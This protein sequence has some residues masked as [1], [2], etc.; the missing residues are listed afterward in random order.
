MALGVEGALH[1]PGSRQEQEDYG[2]WLGPGAESSSAKI[3][4]NGEPQEFTAF[5]GSLSVVA[6]RGS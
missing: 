1:N 5:P 2:G 4:Q 3:A 6:F